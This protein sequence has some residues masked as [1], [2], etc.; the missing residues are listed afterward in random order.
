[1][2][3]SSLPPLKA[4]ALNATLKRSA[5]QNPS[6][7]DRMLHYLD[8]HLVPYGVQTEHVRLSEFNIEPGVTSREA[9]TTSGR[10]SE[11]KSSMRIFL[12]SAR[13]SGSVNH[14]ASASACWNVWMH[15]F[16]RPMMPTEC[17][18]TGMSPSRQWLGTRTGHISCHPSSIR[19]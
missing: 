18:L 7:T 2:T 1:M 19:R 4:I 14:Q 11:P 5:D 12:F 15:F 9:K 10:H 16:Q 17:R 8:T 3:V 13:R 6:S